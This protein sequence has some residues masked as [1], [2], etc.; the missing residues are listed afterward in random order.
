MQGYIEDEYGDGPGV[1]CMCVHRQIT[2]NCSTVRLNT[3]LENP[4]FVI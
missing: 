1:V 4:R 2:H 3:E